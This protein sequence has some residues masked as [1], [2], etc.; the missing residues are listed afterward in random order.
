MQAAADRAGRL[1]EDFLI[2][3]IIP[4]VVAKTA[5]RAREGAAW[6]VNFYINLMGPL[7]R[8]ALIKFGYKKEVESIMEVN[9]GRKSA[10]VPSRAEVLLDQLTLNG[11]PEEVREKIPAWLEN[12]ATMPCLMLNPNLSLD[13]INY[14]VSAIQRT[15]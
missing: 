4:T 3:P 14:S 5:E 9:Q 13:E 10:L 7:Y 8:N 1:R 11:T 15:R 2:I 12:G 6:V